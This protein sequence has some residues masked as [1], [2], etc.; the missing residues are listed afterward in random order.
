MSDA[1][2]MQRAIALA[3]KGIG[4][5]SPNP[6]VGCVI[7]LNDR[8]IG[9]GWHQAYG[10]PH[11]E[12]NAVNTIHDHS[13]LSESTVY[14]TLEPCSHHG[15]TPPCAAML[16]E[17]KVKKVV[18]GTQDPNPLVAGKG[19]AMVKDAGIQVFTGIEA[20]ACRHQN[21]RFFT[22]MEKKRPY[23][24]LKWAQ[25]R[26]GFISRENFDSKWISSPLSR[27][28]VHQWRAEEDTI[29]VG[30]NTVLY[31]NPL[32]NVRDWQGK[33]PLRIVL[34]RYLSLPVDLK[35]FTGEPPAIIYNTI[36]TGQ[37]GTATLVRLPEPSF[38][39]AVFNDLYERSIQ[40]VIA[41]G[42]STIIKELLQRNLWDEARV[43]IAPKEFGKGIPAPRLQE[44]FHSENK[45]EVIQSDA[46]HIILNH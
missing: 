42:G 34:D 10:G 13:L 45:V 38:I 31:D 8:I 27:K 40:S 3:D 24:I 23:I 43:F 4:S 21:R 5:V 37:Q 36:R 44:S 12:V 20:A 33:D 16:I 22:F 46:L 1:I 32:L 30:K 6:L 9:E 19:I 14:V 35:V 7:V 15:K 29:M 28:L 39:N 17:K 26:D 25:T 41:E 18:I 2:Y 11:A